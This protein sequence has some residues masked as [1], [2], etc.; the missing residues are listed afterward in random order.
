MYLSGSW[1]TETLSKDEDFGTGDLNL[2]PGVEASPPRDGIRI[3]MDKLLQLSAI[4]SSV[5]ETSAAMVGRS[6]S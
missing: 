6:S 5:T 1:I 4:V 2:G 3:L